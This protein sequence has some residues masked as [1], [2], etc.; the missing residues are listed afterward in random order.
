MPLLE[1]SI[2]SYKPNMKNS[3][4]SENSGQFNKNY[5]FNKHISI[6]Y[7]MKMETIFKGSTR[8]KKNESCIVLI[9]SFD[10]DDQISMLMTVIHGNKYVCK[11]RD[12]LEVPRQ[13]HCENDVPCFHCATH[14]R[15]PRAHCCLLCPLTMFLLHSFL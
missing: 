14:T 9:F 1:A 2:Q 12:S 5:P 4:S 11:R 3:N 15:I 10:N 6:M 7:I 8:D 13:A